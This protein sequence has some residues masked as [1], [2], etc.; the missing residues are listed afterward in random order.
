MKKK[1]ENFCFIIFFRLEKHSIFINIKSQKKKF[2]G[3]ISLQ[4]F[5]PHRSAFFSMILRLAPVDRKMLNGHSNGP[6]PPEVENYP[7]LADQ[8][9][10]P[11]KIF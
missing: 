4:F 9:V 7:F 10:R 5:A 1:F 11:H 3:Q 6:N 2:S 8:I